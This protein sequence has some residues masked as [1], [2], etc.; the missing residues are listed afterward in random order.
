MTA[1]T[2]LHIVSGTV[3]RSSVLTAASGTGVSVERDGR[4]RVV[5]GTEEQFAGGF[6]AIGFAGRFNAFFLSTLTL[7]TRTSI[8]LI[9]PVDCS[10][11]SADSSV[12]T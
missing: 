8:E 2:T 11:E 1:D 3:D 9:E 4:P 7:R 5:P 6:A 12:N 10:L